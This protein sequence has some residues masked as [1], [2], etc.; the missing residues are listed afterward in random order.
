MYLSSHIAGIIAVAKYLLG[1]S[2]PPPPSNSNWRIL[3]GI[4]LVDPSDPSNDEVLLSPMESLT[5]EDP[6]TPSK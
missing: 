5:F 2:P 6:K 1:L 3:E 4:M